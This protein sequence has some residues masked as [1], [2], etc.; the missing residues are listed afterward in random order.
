M[1]AES[2]SKQRILFLCTGNSCRSQMAE[3][4]LRSLAGARFEVRSAGTRPQGVNARAV[5]A[6]RELGI[7]ISAQSSDHVDSYLGT[8]VDTV[9]T[10]CDHAAE[11]CP[12]F[13]ERVRRIHW[14]FDDPAKATG[15]EAERME[16]FRRVRDEIRDALRNWL[17]GP[18]A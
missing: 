17:A 15:T 10:V 12:T 11:N 1:Q 13:P 14:S 6:M 7:D 8:G 5:A 16:V 18:D 4:L 2:S 9:I 3:G